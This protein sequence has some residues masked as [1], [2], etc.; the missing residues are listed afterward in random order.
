[1]TRRK[2]AGLAAAAGLLVAGIS[3][4][5]G[6]R[7]VHSQ[8]ATQ[9][10][11][12]QHLT[13]PFGASLQQKVRLSALNTTAAPVDVLFLLNDAAGNPVLQKV[14]TIAPG[15]AAYEEVPGG[16]IPKGANDLAGIASAQFIVPQSKPNQVEPPPPYPILPSVEIVD[17]LTGETQ[18]GSLSNL[19]GRTFL[20][21]PHP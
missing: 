15:A 1:M 18:A 14:R 10:P 16:A 8:G 9:L 5:A 21:V 6:A 11:A 17:A 19:N 3:L 2:K 20:P 7:A 4:F 12:V 13:S